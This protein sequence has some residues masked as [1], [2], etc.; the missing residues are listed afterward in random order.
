MT[1]STKNSGAPRVDINHLLGLLGRKKEVERE[2]AT[3]FQTPESRGL[4]T[5]Y[6]YAVIRLEA[7]NGAIEDMKSRSPLEWEGIL[8]D[9]AAVNVLAGAVQWRLCSNNSLSH[10]QTT[11]PGHPSRQAGGSDDGRLQN[12]VVMSREFTRQDCVMGGSGSG[13][14]YQSHAIV[15]RHGVL[16]EG[17]GKTDQ[18][19][20][21]DLNDQYF[22]RRQNIDV[23]NQ[24]S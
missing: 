21:A 8:D 11:A 1:R 6:G 4:G 13:S 9:P 15:V 10:N 22:G 16:I 5:G 19:A 24:S 18:E 3:R 14:T 23:R 20:I 12:R 17:V 2:I 7:I